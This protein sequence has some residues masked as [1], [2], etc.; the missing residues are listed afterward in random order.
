MN[1]TAVIVGSTALFAIVLG[2]VVYVVMKKKDKSSPAP[3]AAVAPASTSTPATSSTTSSAPAAA[4]ATSSTPTNAAPPAPPSTKTATTAGVSAPA[5]SVDPS[6]LPSATGFLSDCTSWYYSTNPESGDYYQDY[7]TACKDCGAN[8]YTS[9]QITGAGYTV[10]GSCPTQENFTMK[11]SIG[12]T[13]LTAAIT[14]AFFVLFVK[15][16]K[17]NK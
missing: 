3:A 14:A 9:S 7:A 10:G 17:L 12:D 13:V 2:V 8:S 15:I 6:T 5:K 11:S 4:V 16:F 1:T